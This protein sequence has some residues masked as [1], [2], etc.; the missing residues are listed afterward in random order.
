MLAR[1]GH[2]V[3]VLERDGQEPPPGPDEAATWNRPTVP[4]YHQAHSMLAAGRRVLADL[5]PD[6]LESLREHGAREFPLIE[7]LPSTAEHR[8]RIDPAMV[9]D[10]VTVGVRRSTLEWVL[11][12]AAGQEPGLRVRSGTVATGLLW[13]DAARPRA[14]GVSTRS[15]EE[16]RADLI[17][18]ATGRRSQLNRWAGSVGVRM[19]EWSHDGA[20]VAYTRFYRL[21]DR[22][23][24]PP[25]LIGG[26]TQQTLDAF[27]IY[28]FLTDNATI[29]V[30][31]GRHP[32]DDTLRALASPAAFEATVSAVPLTAPVIDRDIAEPISDV[33][34]MAGIRNVFRPNLC[35]GLPQ[36][37]GVVAIGDAYATTNPLYGRGLSLALR[38]AEVLVDT[39]WEHPRPGLDQETVLA[40]RLFEATHSAWHDNVRHDDHRIRIWEATLGLPPVPGKPMAGLPLRS[41]FLASRQEADVYVRMLRA[42]Q[43]LDDP[44]D[45]FDDKNL[46]ERIAAMPLQAPPTTTRR[47]A[48]DAIERARRPLTGGALR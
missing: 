10:L 11:R 9:T 43:L 39:L 14:I 33:H 26:A 45:F 13:D 20:A 29:S 25:M 36:V 37:T 30:A 31:V 38:Q 1:A 18:D 15:G 28:A 40:H 42:M 46:I 24:S 4:Q 48:L 6:V 32:E 2:Q 3:T 21:R 12:T 47:D 7:W 34:V 44:A 27:G 23:V 8:E 35:G 41:A 5:L 16:L 17:V 22:E 19:R